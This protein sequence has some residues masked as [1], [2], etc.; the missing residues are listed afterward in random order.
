MQQRGATSTSNGHF[1][2]TGGLQGGICFTKDLEIF[3][4]F[5][6]APLPPSPH[7]FTE[8]PPGW[9]SGAGFGVGFRRPALGRLR[10][11]FW[12]LAWVCLRG[13]PPLVGLGVGW[14]RW[15]GGGSGPEVGPWGVWVL[16]WGCLPGDPP[17]V[18][19]GVGWPRRAG[20]GSTSGYPANPPPR[21]GFGPGYL[22]KA[23]SQGTPGVGRD[24]KVPWGWGATWRVRVSRIRPKNRMK[25]TL[26]SHA[27]EL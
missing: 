23:G 18:G 20:G 15:A 17:L 21:G 6:A 3:S 26:K 13:D 8:V 27:W 25:A 11:G 22:V 1:W 24:E 7:L 9:V 10:G 5:V 4:T 12:W 14:P 2:S 16:V 19:F